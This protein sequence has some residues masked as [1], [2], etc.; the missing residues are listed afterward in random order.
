MEGGGARQSQRCPGSTGSDDTLVPVPACFAQRAPSAVLP[1]PGQAGKIVPLL[2][3]SNV[4]YKVDDK[5]E[6][7]FNHTRCFIRDDTGRRVR[8]ARTHRSTYRAPTEHPPG[9]YRAPTGP[10]QKHLPSTPTEGPTELLPTPCASQAAA[11]ASQAAF[12]RL[13]GCVPTSF[14]RPHSHAPQAAF[15]R[16]SQAYIPTHPRARSHVFPKPAFPRTPGRVSTS[17]PSLHSHAPQARTDALLKEAERSLRMLDAFVSRTLHLI[18]TPCHIAQQS[19]GLINARVQAQTCTPPCA[20]QAA[21]SHSH[22]RPCTPDTPAPPHP[23]TLK[24]LHLCTPCC[25]SYRRGCRPLRRSGSRVPRC[26]ST[27]RCSNS[28]RSAQMLPRCCPDV[29]YRLPPHPL[30]SAHSS[31]TDVPCSPLTR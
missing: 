1:R 11:C 12:P 10:L 28:P 2:I 29:T 19:L 20:S 6:K 30:S 15:P 18:K 8:E 5:G 31:R 23:C 22:R 17:F 21:P 7:A 3:D 24:P 27:D 9:T 16:L 26:C 25:R 13:P 4:A 14:Q